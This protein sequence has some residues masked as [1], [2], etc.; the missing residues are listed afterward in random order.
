MVRRVR[1]EADAT[2]GALGST[3]HEEA[4]GRVGRVDEEIAA[5]V[6]V[7]DDAFAVGRIDRYGSDGSRFT[8]DDAGVC[9]EGL[10]LLAQRRVCGV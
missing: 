7:A 9:Q 2:A 8:A 1:A 4:R 6:E 3:F 10:R 5:S